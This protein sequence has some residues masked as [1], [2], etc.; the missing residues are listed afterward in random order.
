MP[1]KYI[2]EIK[3]NIYS[4]FLNHPISQ[5]FLSQQDHRLYAAGQ[6]KETICELGENIYSYASIGFDDL[7][8]IKE[9]GVI[10]YLA[11]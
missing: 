8:Y 9:G 6:I 11:G 10:N 5:T 2:Q 1:K 3:Y 4:G 7:V